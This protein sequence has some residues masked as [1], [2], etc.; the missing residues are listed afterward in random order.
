MKIKFTIVCVLALG[1]LGFLNSCT[2]VEQR[3][4]VTHTTTTTTEQTTVRQPQTNTV[5]TRTI[6][7][8]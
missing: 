8:N 1:G 7:S 2:T 4:P 3:E 5:E 6:R